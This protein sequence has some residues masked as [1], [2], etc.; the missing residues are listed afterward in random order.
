MS[1]MELYLKIYPDGTLSWIPLFRKPRFDFGYNGAEVLDVSDLYPVIGCSCVELVHTRIG[2]VVILVD[3]SGKVKDPSLKVN[4]LA[5]KL[6]AGAPYGDMIHGPAVVFALRP[7]PH[8]HGQD[9]FPLNKSELNLLSVCLG[10]PIPEV[11][12]V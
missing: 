1:K 3:E 10:V 12:H 8:N 7:L 4:P 2:R 9:L 6:Y 5:S 11:P